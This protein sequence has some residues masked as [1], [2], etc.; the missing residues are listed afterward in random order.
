M[1]E[2]AHELGNF[3]HKLYYWADYI[4]SESDAPKRAD[5]TVGLMLERTVAS[6]EEFLK[7]TLDYFN[8]IALNFS[9]LPVEELCDGFLA[10][11]RSLPSGASVH[12]TREEFPPSAA[13]LVDP[14]RISQ[15]FRNALHHVREEL[16]G[17]GVV[18]VR[19]N[20]VN[21]G[22][23][24][25]VEIGVGMEPKPAAPSFFRAGETGVEWALAEKLLGLHGGEI[26]ERAESHGGKAVVIFLPVYS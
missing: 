15:A 12:I 17:G 13:L 25:G 16:K 18:L 20:A 9:R 8:P 5:S 22:N 4:K 21:R 19:F 11:L 14:N 10:H 6:L 24:E 23:V 26:V 7:V 2:I 3:F 1:G